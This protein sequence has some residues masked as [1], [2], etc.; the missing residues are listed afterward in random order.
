VASVPDKQPTLTPTRRTQI[1]LAAV[2]AGLV[3]A[4]YAQ[5]Y[6]HGFVEYDDPGYVGENAVVRRGLTLYGVRW[7]FTTGLLGNW[8]PLTWL[9]YMLD[10]QL[11]GADAGALHLVNVALHL[12]NTLLLF[13]V[14][15]RMTRA[16]WPSFA[17]AA[18]FAIHPLHVE[19]IAADL[20][21]RVY[22]EH[23]YGERFGV[24]DE[25]LA[26]CVAGLRTRAEL[27]AECDVI[28]LPK[29]QPL[30][31]GGMR[32]GQV[33]WGWPHCVQDKE[34]TQVSVDRRLTLI[35]F[36]AMNY[37]SASGSFR[38]HVFHKNNEMAGYCS[39]LHALELVGMTGD[40]GRRL[41]AAHSGAFKTGKRRQTAACLVD[42]VAGRRIPAAPQC[43]PR[44]GNRG[45]AC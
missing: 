23:G 33:L 21:E 35:A 28:L 6:R 42:R 29:P 14:L 37:W 17:V 44:T 16:R 43:A 41:R 5:T 39:V 25:H 11:F 34:I 10:V 7:A 4:V 8:N 3:L 19:R 15:L 30:D 32:E 45:A 40:Y 26:A 9:S 22:L 38:L 1:A 2:L 13:A 18:L 36:E 27:V 31:L 20:R 24:P 12:V